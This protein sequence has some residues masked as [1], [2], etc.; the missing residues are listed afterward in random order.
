[1]SLKPDV[2]RAGDARDRLGSHLDEIESRF[3]PQYVWRLARASGKHSAKRHPAAWA[4]GGTAVA[5]TVLGLLGWAI[6]SRD[7]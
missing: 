4:L 1:M 2:R 6:F 7:D 3:M 5:A